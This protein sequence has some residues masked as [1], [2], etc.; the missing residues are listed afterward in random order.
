MSKKI[1]EEHSWDIELNTKGLGLNTIVC[2]CGNR[3]GFTDS[4]QTHLAEMLAEPSNFRAELY[5]H[6][7]DNEEGVRKYDL[8][9][10]EQLETILTREAK[11]HDAYLVDVWS[12][13][14]ILFTLEI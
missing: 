3:Y 13:D 6:G 8:D 4:Y 10:L 11:F 1:L 14:N 5:C 2:K 12:G 9:S 7:E